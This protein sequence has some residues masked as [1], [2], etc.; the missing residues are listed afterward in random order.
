MKRTAL[1]SDM[2]MFKS[3]L[4]HLQ[5]ITLSE[6]QF[7]ICKMGVIPHKNISSVRAGTL[8]LLFASVS[9]RLEQCQAQVIPRSGFADWMI[10]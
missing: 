4:C 9:P 3:L 7:L 1:E 6:P 8:C 2:P 5:P 10:G